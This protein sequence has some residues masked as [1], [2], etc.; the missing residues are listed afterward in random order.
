MEEMAVLRQARS[1][2]SWNYMYVKSELFDVC[3]RLCER[4][5]LVAFDGNDRNLGIRS[6]YLCDNGRTELELYDHQM[7][8]LLCSF[9]ENPE[10]PMPKVLTDEHKLLNKLGLL[11]LLIDGASGVQIAST[12]ILHDVLML[13]NDDWIRAIDDIERWQRETIRKGRR[14]DAT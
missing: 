13:P 8:E 3:D 14:V 11:R 2:T 10:Q 4:E 12:A 9:Q 1:T 7:T 5:M 6:Y